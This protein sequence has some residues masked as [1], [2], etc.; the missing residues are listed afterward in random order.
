MIALQ[1]WK[2][3]AVRNRS[4]KLTDV[5]TLVALINVKKVKEVAWVPEMYKTGGEMQD[6]DDTLKGL[7][8]CRYEDTLQ[9]GT[10]MMR[11]VTVGKIGQKRVSALLL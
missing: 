6:V 3:K 5:K 11:D 2:D 10:S 7:Y 4:R 8:T 1:H 9:G